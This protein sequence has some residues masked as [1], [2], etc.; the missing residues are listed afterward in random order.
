VSKEDTSPLRWLSVPLD[1]REGE[2]EMEVNGELFP[3]LFSLLSS[4]VSGALKVQR[5]RGHLEAPGRPQAVDTTGESNIIL[6]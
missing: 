5:V 3:L 4:Q 2:K 1:P 6:L